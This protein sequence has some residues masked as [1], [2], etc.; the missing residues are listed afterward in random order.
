MTSGATESGDFSSVE[1][2]STF[3]TDANGIWSGT[4][5]FGD[6]YVYTDSLG[7]LAV[8]NVPE[9]STYVLLALGMLALL[10]S[11]RRRV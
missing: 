2:G 4:N 6:T 11:E 10:I 7:Q 8:T 1:V 9:P 5:N 3:L